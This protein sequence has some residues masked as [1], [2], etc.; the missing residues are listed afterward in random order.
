MIAVCVLAVAI[1][2]S[3]CSSRA[4]GCAPERREFVE[5]PL[6]LGNV[7]A[8]QGADLVEAGLADIGGGRPRT[9][10]GVEVGVEPRLRVDRQLEEALAHG[11]DPLHLAAVFG[12]DPKTAIRYAENA[13]LLL[14]TRAEEQNPASSREPK[15]RNDP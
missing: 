1:A 5:L 14:T 12:L 4:G 3:G 2:G 8:D 9:R 15:G 11:P 10:D 13:R 7:A 6:C